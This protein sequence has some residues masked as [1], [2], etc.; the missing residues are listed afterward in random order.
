MRKTICIILFF[1]LNT[2]LLAQNNQIG[3]GIGQGD[4]ID[5]TKY[6]I[7]NSFTYKLLYTKIDFIHTPIKTKLYKK[8]NQLLLLLGIQSIPQYKVIA[9][10]S[11][12]ARYLIP[13]SNDVVTNTIQLKP[14]INFFVNT[15]LT[16]NFYKKHCIYSDIYILGVTNKSQ[17]IEVN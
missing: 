17:Q 2:Q 8:T 1:Y 11:M 13:I 7:Y 5:D 10:V 6:Q 15:G 4:G 14:Q 3:L 12:G 9:H 16:Y